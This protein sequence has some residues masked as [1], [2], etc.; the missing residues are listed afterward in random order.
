M[1]V[2]VTNRVSYENLHPVKYGMKNT[3]HSVLL[4][5]L[6]AKGFHWGGL[7]YTPVEFAS[8]ALLSQSIQRGKKYVIRLAHN[9]FLTLL[10]LTP[11]V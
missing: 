11:L 5:V 2:I 1:L 3:F 8:L 10:K 6:L 9:I 4:Q 7:Y